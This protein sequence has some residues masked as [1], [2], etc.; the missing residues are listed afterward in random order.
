[1]GADAVVVPPPLSDLCLSYW[2][3]GESAIREWGCAAADE[4]VFIWWSGASIH[5]IDAKAIAAIGVA[6]AQGHRLKL[7]AGLDTLHV[8]GR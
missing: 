6:L 2:L 3:G 8:I 1:M 7:A 4:G 5:E